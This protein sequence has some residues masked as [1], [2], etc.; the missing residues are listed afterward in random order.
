MG[1]IEVVHED[2]VEWRAGSSYERDG[3]VIRT[4]SRFPIAHLEPGPWLGRV[5]YEPHMRIEE[6]WHPCNEI[7]YIT[8]GELTVGET[9]YAVGT[10]LAIEEGTVYGPLIAGPEGA[11]FLTIR[12][13]HP[14]GLMKP[15]DS[16]D[17][18]SKP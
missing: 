18:E 17:R 3:K 12:D 4:H 11:E 14:K 10:A 8:K 9:V 15:D 1:K 16:S 6:H 13:K 5:W 7:L 2:A